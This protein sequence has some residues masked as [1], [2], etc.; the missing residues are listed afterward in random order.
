MVVVEAVG[1]DELVERV[2]LFRIACRIE[3]TEELLGLVVVVVDK[4]VLTILE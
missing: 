3:S 2:L 1:L 4:G